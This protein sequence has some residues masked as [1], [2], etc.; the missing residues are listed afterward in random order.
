VEVGGSG[1]RVRVWGVRFFGGGVEGFGSGRGVLRLGVGV[2]VRALLCQAAHLK[3]R[4]HPRPPQ[5]RPEHSITTPDHTRRPRT[6]ELVLVVL[7]HG[8][9]L[10][11]VILDVGHVLSA[12]PVLG[13][14][15]HKALRAWSGL[16][17]VIR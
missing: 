4:S 17:W 10:Q 6:P 5:S 11:D 8:Q 9:V 16:V 15:A 2:G 3:K 1:G 14:G 13:G 7:E 12:H